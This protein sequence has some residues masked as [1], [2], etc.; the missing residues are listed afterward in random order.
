M[1]DNVAITAGSGTTIAAD[2]IG[3]VLHQRVK[4]SQGADGSA[5]DVSSA[6]PLQVSLANT[7]ANATSVVVDLGANNDVTIAALTDKTQFAKVTDGTETWA[8]DTHNSGVVTLVDSSGNAVTF[9]S[10]G[11][12]TSANSAPVVIASDQ[13]WPVGTTGFMKKEDVAS[14]D[15]DAGIPAMV[16]RQA[17]A[18]LADSSG[19]AGDYEFLRIKDGRLWVQTGALSASATFTPGAGANSAGDCV[20]AAAEIDFNAPAASRIMITSATLYVDNTAALATNWRLHLY[21][22]TPSSAIA[23]NGAWDFAD[24]DVTQYLGYIDLGSTATDTG[25][26]Q[27][28]QVDGI[29][30]QI[31]LAGDSV[32]AY[33]TTSSGVTLTATSHVVTL[34][35]VVL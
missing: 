11:S 16:V 28:T 22:V 17:A 15:G 7:G 29:N 33:L 25:T 35:A 26:N 34:H 24:A 4:I 19:T 6:A 23:D 9:N 32:F 12:A 30:K 10:N 18:S 13:D 8:I 20:G 14:A 31:V 1:V 2:D 21:N 5:T 3:G 27:W